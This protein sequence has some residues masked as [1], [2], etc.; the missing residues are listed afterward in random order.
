M[1]GGAWCCVVAVVPGAGV[2]C[3]VCGGGVRLWCLVLVPGGG[4]VRVGGAGRCALLLGA[5]APACRCSCALP[6]GCLPQVA[7]DE[8]GLTAFQMDIKVEGITT[9][10]PGLGLCS[11][12]WCAGCVL[13]VCWLAGWLAGVVVCWWWQCVWCGV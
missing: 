6:P 5:E 3:V 11:V 1:A 4:W 12:C 9:G 13:A 10:G 2:W 7:G 8:S